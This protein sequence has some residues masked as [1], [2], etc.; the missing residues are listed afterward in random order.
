MAKEVEELQ[1]ERLILRG[2]REEDAPEIVRWRTDP[3]V[4]RFFKNPQKIT[5]ESHLNWFR[6]NYL[7]DENRFD[8]ICLE[9]ET[10]NKIGVFGLVLRD[11]YAEINY[12]L[13]PEAQHKGYA[14]EAIRCNISFVKVK[15]NLKKF[16]AEIHEDNSSS[17]SLVEKLEF[18][19]SRNNGSFLVYSKEVT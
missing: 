16:V 2:I 8:W 11:D 18:E 19:Y 3:E 17:I 5:I 14:R 13:A 6:T 15:Y 7:Q 4:Y 1:T 10:G 12:L 9:K